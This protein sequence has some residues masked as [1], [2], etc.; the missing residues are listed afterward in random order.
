MK[1]VRDFFLAIDAARRHSSEPRIDLRV[2]GSAALMLQTKHVRGTKD[3]DVIETATLDQASKA[4]LLGLAG[5]GSTLHARHRMY[6]EVVPS[7][8]P[9]LPQ[10][11]RWIEAAEINHDLVT[12]RIEVLGIADVLVSKL[13]PFRPND[14]IDIEAMI[15]GGH[16]D[17]D[18]LIERFKLAMDAFLMDAR[19]QDLHEVVRNLHQVERDLF[20]VAE[21]EIELPP[22]LAG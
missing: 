16:V 5:K 19:A 1:L 18:D 2:I 14:R 10:Q 15:D 6:L 7:S 12:M 17:H 3:A 4:N 22:W 20:D 11:P 21:S 9:L 13:K 8:F